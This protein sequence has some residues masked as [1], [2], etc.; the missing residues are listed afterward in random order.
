MKTI[1]FSGIDGSGKSTVADKLVRKL[2]AGGK[3]VYRLHAV[4]FSIA[5]KLHWGSKSAKN[6]TTPKPAITTATPWQVK[7]RTIA[8]MIDLWRYYSFVTKLQKQGY[9]Y[10]ISDRYFFD[11]VVNIRYLSGRNLIYQLESFVPLPDCAFLMD[12]DPAIVKTRD[13]APEQSLKYLTDKAHYLTDRTKVWKLHHLDA[14]QTPAKVFADVC[15]EL[16]KKEL[17]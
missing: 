11:M 5:N 10:L 3:R 9:D 6:N 7:L 17:L 13:R 8:L 14:N 1:T 16:E 12:I 2:E 4:E 15:E